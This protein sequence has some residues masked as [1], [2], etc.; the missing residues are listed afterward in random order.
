MTKQ[1]LQLADYSAPESDAVAALERA[2]L[3]GDLSQLSPSERL[4]YYR[5]VC[6]SL[7]L[8]PLTRPFDYLKLNGR[9]VLYAKKEATDQLRTLHDVSITQLDRVRDG[10]LYVVT[11]YARNKAGREDADMGIVTVKGLSGDALG[12]AMMKAVTKAKRR[13]TLAICGLGWLD[14]TEVETIP[15]ARP[16]LV[17]DQGYIVEPA[18]PTPLSY[19][20]RWLAQFRAVATE[21]AVDDAKQEAI[22][23]AF[24]R[25]TGNEGDGI[26]VIAWALPPNQDTLS[27]A[28]WEA[29]ENT[30]AKGRSAHWA[31]LVAAADAANSADEG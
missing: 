6:R 8:N 18:P 30:L 27:V 14:E 26:A 9:L 23:E 31:D 1:A 4:D 5:G 16:V 11:A 20:D 3:V 10:D 19:A 7:G 17:S 12:N 28:Q 15:D 2:A 13:V 24:D 22:I 25:A 21:P 29:I